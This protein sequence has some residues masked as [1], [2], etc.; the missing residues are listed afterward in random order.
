LAQDAEAPTE[1]NVKAWAN[2]PDSLSLR[3]AAL[4]APKKI[5]RAFSAPQFDCSDAGAA[6]PGFGIAPSER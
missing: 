6:G 3:T 1:P 5:I 2:G 4:K